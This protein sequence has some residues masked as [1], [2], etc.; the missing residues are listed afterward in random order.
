MYGELTEAIVITQRVFR[1]P[2]EMMRGQVMTP[3]QLGLRGLGPVQIHRLVKAGKI[4]PVHGVDSGVLGYVR[5]EVDP[6]EALSYE[7]RRAATL[8]RRHPNA[9]LCY[10]A[11]LRVHNLTDDDQ[12]DWVAAVAPG[13]NRVS[14]LSG[15]VLIQ[16]GDPKLFTVGIQYVNILGRRV[17][18]TDPERTVLDCLRGGPR[19]PEPQ[20]VGDALA[21]LLRRA[22]GSDEPLQRM[23]RM[24]HELGVSA[25]MQ[26]VLQAARASLEALD[27][28]APREPE[29]AVPWQKMR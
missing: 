8:A 20:V 4:T 1:L 15:V 3:A 28:S 5:A 22:Q 29:G 21:E 13:R 6:E 12:A 18:V 25:Q 10:Q 11:A 2:S 27:G 14:S 19:A 17:M 24:A 16:W 23:M 26:P 7:G 9:V